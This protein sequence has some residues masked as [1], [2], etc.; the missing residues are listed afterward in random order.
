L[1][2]CQECVHNLEEEKHWLVGRHQ[3]LDIPPIKPIVRE[4]HRYRVIC[5]CCKQEQIA[6]YV[7]GFEKGRKFGANVESLALYLHYDHPQYF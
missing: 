6:D 5:S 3:V 7:E 4:T 2:F 1:E